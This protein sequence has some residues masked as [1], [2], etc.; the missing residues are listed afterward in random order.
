MRVMRL[1]KPSPLSFKPLTKKHQLYMPCFMWFTGRIGVFSARKEK[2]IRL[3]GK[4]MRSKFFKQLF[5]PKLTFPVFNHSVCPSTVKLFQNCY[6]DHLIQGSQTQFHT[7]TT[8]RQK[9]LVASI[10]SWKCLKNKNKC[11]LST[12]WVILMLPHKRIRRSGHVLR[13]LI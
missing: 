9:Q 2:I 12:I 10:E 7:R 13:P 1:A 3:K 11:N 5:L 6:L 8:F 4:K